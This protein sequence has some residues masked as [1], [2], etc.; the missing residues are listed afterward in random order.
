M[1]DRGRIAPGL[2]ADLVLLNGDPTLE[3]AATP[4]IVQ[5]WKT[6]TPVDRESWRQRANSVKPNGAL[7]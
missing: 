1:S 3:I 4:E 2:R 6:G 7:Q 5:V